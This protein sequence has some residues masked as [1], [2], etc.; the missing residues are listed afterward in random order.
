[1]TTLRGASLHCATWLAMTPL[2]I[3][4]AALMR[5][6]GWLLDKAGA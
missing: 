1:M 3:L 4:A 2:L 6:G 5:L